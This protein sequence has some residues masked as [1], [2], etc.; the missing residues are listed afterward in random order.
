[1]NEQTGD[2]YRLPSEA[3]WEYAARANTNAESNAEYSWGDEIGTNH[4]NCY[5]CGS[6]WDASQTAPIG[7]FQANAFGLYDMHGNVWEWMQDCFM[8]NYQDAPQNGS[9]YEDDK[10]E[11]RV[12]RGGSWGEFP[13]FLR[14]ASRFRLTPVVRYFYLGFRL[15]QDL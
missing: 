4:A 13:Q 8:D 14:S 6:A 2:E 10:C 9:A 5:G 1:M 3:E 12:L 11:F 7:S 15:A